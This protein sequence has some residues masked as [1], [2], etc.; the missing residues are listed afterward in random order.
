M[1]G[2][3]P[4]CSVARVKSLMAHMHESHAEV[5]QEIDATRDLT[6]ELQEQLKAAVDAFSPA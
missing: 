2:V 3:S 5:L 1:S 6:P 4:C